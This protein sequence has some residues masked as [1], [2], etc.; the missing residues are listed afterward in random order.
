MES[1]ETPTNPNVYYVTT[2]T[3][4]RFY[5]REAA[6]DYADSGNEQVEMYERVEICKAS[7][8]FQALSCVTEDRYLGT[9]DSSGFQV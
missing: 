4:V 6:L 9:F 1:T 5:D 3:D 7:A 8:D 2:D